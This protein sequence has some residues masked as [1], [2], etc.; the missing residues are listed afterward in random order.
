M[1]KGSSSI[2]W[3][4]NNTFFNNSTN[5]AGGA[6]CLHESSIRSWNGERDLPESPQ[7]RQALH[8]RTR[9]LSYGVAEIPRL[10][11]TTLLTTEAQLWWKAH[12]QRLGRT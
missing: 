10:A 9:L 12:R 7:S 3:D 2:S 6:A 11:I 8:D 1:A 4:G 5:S